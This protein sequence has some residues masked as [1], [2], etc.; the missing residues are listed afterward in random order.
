MLHETYAIFKL[1]PWCNNQRTG[2]YFGFRAWRLTD[3]CCQ[4]HW[5]YT[6]AILSK[7]SDYHPSTKSPNTRLRYVKD[8]KWKFTAP[9]YFKY[10]DRHSEIFTLKTTWGT[11]CE[12]VL[13]HMI[14]II[15][16]RAASVENSHQNR[17]SYYG[18]CS[19]L[20]NGTNKP[21]SVPVSQM[22]IPYSCNYDQKW[23]WLST[24]WLLNYRPPV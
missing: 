6:N 13:F 22:Y 7:L 18:L 15:A 23:F 5:D 21:S 4:M 24:F 11:F 19:K 12:I 9:V 14:P 2:W 20:S 17:I 8:D 10:R 3:N 16:Y 1:I